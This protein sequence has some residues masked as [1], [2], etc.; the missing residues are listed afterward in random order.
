MS[1]GNQVNPSLA[2]R[3]AGVKV[4]QEASTDARGRPQQVID[5]LDAE[6]K[7]VRFN[8][9]KGVS[10]TAMY[11]VVGGQYYATKDTVD[12]CEKQLYPMTAWMKEAVESH[13]SKR[14]APVVTAAD[15]PKND[16]VDVL[17]GT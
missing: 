4:A 10:R 5:V 1:L 13:Q 6:I 7:F 17:G 8:D 15:L 14:Q 11:F 2:A 9:E 12:W 16:S 3:M